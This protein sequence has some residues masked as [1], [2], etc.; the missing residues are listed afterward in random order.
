MQILTRSERTERARRRKARK[1]TAGA[2]IVTRPVSDA[3]R[4]GYERID[5]QRTAKG[6]VTE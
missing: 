6:T 1:S 2:H 4:R 5:W 3:Y